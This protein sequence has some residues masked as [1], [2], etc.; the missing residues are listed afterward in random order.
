MKP[1]QSHLV[2]K[3]INMKKVRY[4]F[5][6]LNE[7]LLFFLILEDNADKRKSY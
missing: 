7:Q 3:Y 1:I 6:P 4:K 2:I 5:C